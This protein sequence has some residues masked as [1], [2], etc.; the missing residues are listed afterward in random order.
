MLTLDVALHPIPL[1][2]ALLISLLL[3]R[4]FEPQFKFIWYCFI[5][6]LG[7]VDQKGRLDKVGPRSGPTSCLK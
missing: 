7:S 6:P 2:F 4:V 1:F 3:A 5:R